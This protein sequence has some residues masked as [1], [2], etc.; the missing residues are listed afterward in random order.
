M[1]RAYSQ[2]FKIASNNQQP[3][4]QDTIPA[5]PYFLLLILTAL[6]GGSARTP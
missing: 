6:M 2:R 3:L 1:E 5:F 4:V